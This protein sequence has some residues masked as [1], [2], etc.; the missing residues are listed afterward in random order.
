[1]AYFLTATLLGAGVFLGVAFFTTLALLD[2]TFFLGAAFLV[3][4]FL[5]E[6]FAT[7]E[8]GL[9]DFLAT[10]FLVVLFWI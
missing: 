10:V 9:V 4:A 2:T 1:M 3:A 7:L 6:V 5:V 8:T